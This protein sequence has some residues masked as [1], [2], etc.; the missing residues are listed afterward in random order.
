MKSTTATRLLV[1]TLLV[2]LSFMLVAGCSGSGETTREK[3][4]PN[5]VSGEDAARTPTVRLAGLIVQRVAGITLSETSGGRIKVRVRGVTSFT[6]DNQPL[7]VV[8]DIPVDPEP[9]GSL[10]GVVLTEIESIKVYKYPADT[11]R[12]GMRGANGVIVV[13]T[14]MGGG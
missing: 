3:P 1:T 7:F 10:P 13:K 9:D 2:G 11:S 6:S 5:T 8:D 12:W 14:K 4:E